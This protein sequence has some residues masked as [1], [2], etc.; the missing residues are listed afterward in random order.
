MKTTI[1]YFFFEEDNFIIQSN[2]NNSLETYF[3]S[4]RL[5]DSVMEVKTKCDVGFWRIKL[6]DKQIN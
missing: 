3:W 5:L 2:Y 4:Y 1:K 6:K